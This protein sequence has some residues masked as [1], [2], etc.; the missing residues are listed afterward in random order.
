MIELLEAQLSRC[1]Y[2]SD[3]YFMASEEGCLTTKYH[4]GRGIQFR[5]KPKRE[6]AIT[7]AEALSRELEFRTRFIKLMHCE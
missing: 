3:K 2:E 1:V 6:F 5:I 4:Q 7:A